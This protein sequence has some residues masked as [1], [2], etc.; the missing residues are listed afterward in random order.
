MER[1]R[2]IGAQRHPFGDS[3]ANQIDRGGKEKGWYA[4]PA[5]IADCVSKRA[6]NVLSTRVS[7]IP[8]QDADEPAEHSNSRATCPPIVG[9]SWHGSSL[10][11]VSPAHGEEA[12][13]ARHTDQV[14]HSPGL[15]PGDGTAEGGDAVVPPAFVSGR[16][17][18]RSRD[19]SNEVIGEH[20]AQKAVQGARLELPAPAGARIG[21][22]DDPVAVG[23]AFHQRQQDRKDVGPEREETGGVCRNGRHKLA[24]STIDG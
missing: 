22:L 2:A 9:S 24:R 1:E 3:L 15:G 5:P 4:T 14:F 19:F 12:P 17:R 6:E 8:G 18:C 21:P 11:R 16:I 20:L 23:V 10:A 13:V 7:Q